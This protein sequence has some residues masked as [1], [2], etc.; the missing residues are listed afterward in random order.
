MRA[1]APRSARSPPP[2]RLVPVRQ[3]A[4]ARRELAKALAEFLDD[5]DNAHGGLDMSEYMERHMA[6][7]LLVLL[8]YADSE[9]GLLTGAVRQRPMLLFDE[10]E[11]R[12][13]RVLRRRRCVTR[14][15]RDFTNTVVIDDQQDRV[16]PAVV[17]TPPRRQNA[18]RRRG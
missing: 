17:G 5:A 11:V 14:P 13:G 1:A 8:G 2:D 3:A 15:P 7:R 16:P 18:R 12:R 4:L 6:Q 9:G 10:V